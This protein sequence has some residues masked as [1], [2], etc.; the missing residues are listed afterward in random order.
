METADR[1]EVRGLEVC[2]E[3]ADAPDREIEDAWVAD[4]VLSVADS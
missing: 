3:I 4:A 1:E 2:V